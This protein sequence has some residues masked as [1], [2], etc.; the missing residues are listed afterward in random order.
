MVVHDVLAGEAVDHVGGRPEEHVRGGEDLRLVALHPEDLR[1][2]RLRG[3]RHAAQVEHRLFAE[4][5]VEPGDLV[6]GPRV[7]AVEDPMPQRPPR[8]I[9]REHAGADG[10]DRHPADVLAAVS[11]AQELPR[12]PDELA[13]PD[14]IGVVLRPTGPRQAEPMLDRRLGQHLTVG[15]AEHA[16]RA[17]GA[18][19]DA[20]QQVAGHPS[21]PSRRV[22]GS[23]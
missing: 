2:D 21:L 14:G 23:P 13:P 8:G 15:R 19:I 17:V 7:D 3:E 12:Q 4:S 16:L 1:T 22:C 9:D 20:E 10:A 6:R 11:V 5:L 18:D